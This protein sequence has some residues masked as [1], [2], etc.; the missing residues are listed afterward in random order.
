MSAKNVASLKYFFNVQALLGNSHFIYGFQ[1]LKNVIKFEDF[2]FFGSARKGKK[3]LMYP[4]HILAH[5]SSHDITKKRKV[6]L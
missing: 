1:A 4:T 5:F 2:M 3:A 6:V